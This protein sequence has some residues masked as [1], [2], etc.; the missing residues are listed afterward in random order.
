MADAG[1]WEPPPSPYEQ[2]YRD[3]LGEV[4]ALSG[5]VREA[6]E[7]IAVLEPAVLALWAANTGLCYACEGPIGMHTP[8]CIVPV[9]IAKHEE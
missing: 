9:V 7:Q 1:N 8:D 4:D 6:N 5:L 3:A 2:L